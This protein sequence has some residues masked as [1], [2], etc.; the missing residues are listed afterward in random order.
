MADSRSEE[1]TLYNVRKDT[2][3]AKVLQQIG[4]VLTK[5]VL[6]RIK[7]LGEEMETPFPSDEWQSYDNFMRGKD[8]A[9]NGTKLFDIEV[10]Y[11]VED[12]DGE[13]KVKYKAKPD[14][15][16]NLIAKMKKVSFEPKQYEK[17]VK[18]LKKMVNFDTGCRSLLVT[19]FVYLLD[20]IAVAYGD[21]S[22][23]EDQSLE[24]LKS[25]IIES[26]A[27]RKCKIFKLLCDSDS[28]V[29]TNTNYSNFISDDVVYGF[30]QDF[31]TIVMNACK[32]R[33]LASETARLFMSFLRNFGTHV[34]NNVWAHARTATE[35]LENGETVTRFNAAGKTITKSS[36]K[37]FM[38]QAMYFLVPKESRQSL[39]FFNYIVESDSF[40]KEREESERK[41]KADAGTVGR[42]AK[43]PDQK[44][45]TE[46]VNSL[47]REHLKT[48]E[49]RD[50]T[51]LQS[52]PA[53]APDAKPP[54]HTPTARPPVRTAGPP[55]R[56]GVRKVPPSPMK[57]GPP[58]K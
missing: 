2:F 55:G 35:T 3:T 52:A 32:I 21:L 26:N 13:G 19:V 38:M 54:T 12:V 20:E 50:T 22:S 30:N 34:T 43:A 11:E 53:P 39:S 10:K 6:A 1:E 8:A 42:L 29:Q 37:E 24:N 5:V 36:L 14:E 47:I 56:P 25:I 15:N 16:G 9:V 48:M 33:C 45:S 23:A 31:E 49:Q 57:R 41:K 18:K 27:S 17:G 7:F 4:T 51:P 58:K 40:F 28:N 44:Q 46:K